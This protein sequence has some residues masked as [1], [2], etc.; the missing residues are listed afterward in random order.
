MAKGNGGP[1]RA[2]KWMRWIAR[3]WSLPIIVSALVVLVGYAWNWV[4]IGGADPYAVEDYPPTEALAPI[5]MFLSVLGLGI[6]GVGNDWEGRL[7]LFSNWQRF[8]C[9]VF[10]VRSLAIFPVWRFLI[11][12]R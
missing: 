1:D 11:F 3:I 12:S 9:S 2:T 4:T 7:S 10:I 8:W 5:F 6:A